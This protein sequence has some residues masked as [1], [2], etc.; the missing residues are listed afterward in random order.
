MVP[1]FK[2]LSP[3]KRSNLSQKFALKAFFIESVLRYFVLNFYRKTNQHFFLY[4]HLNRTCPY[5][6]LKDFCHCGN[7]SWNPILVFL[8]TRRVKY[9]SLFLFSFPSVVSC[10]FQVHYSVG[11]VKSRADNC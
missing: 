6:F 10:K 5:L 3:N 4:L 7:N 8:M 2:T 11:A 9:S 1:I